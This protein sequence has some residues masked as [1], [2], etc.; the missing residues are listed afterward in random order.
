MKLGCPISYVSV[1]DDTCGIVPHVV[2]SD[3]EGICAKL[4]LW[5]LLILLHWH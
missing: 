3:T 1:L 5:P 4:Q 2:D